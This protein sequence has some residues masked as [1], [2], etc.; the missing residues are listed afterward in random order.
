MTSEVDEM[1]AASRGSQ[2]DAIERLLKLARKAHYCCEDSW[3][4]CPLAED[5]CAN[6]LYPKDECNCG[7]DERNAEVDAIAATLRPLLD[8]LS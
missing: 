5:V 6:D 8:S 4:S 1:S 3:Y 7:A 2:R